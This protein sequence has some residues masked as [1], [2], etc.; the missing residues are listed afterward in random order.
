MNNRKKSILLWILSVIIMLA[1]ASWQRMSG[2]TY[3]KSGEVIID[4]EVV[5][6]KLLRSFDSG[7]D[8]L[9]SILIS[10]DNISGNVLYKR[11]NTNDE[12]TKIAMKKCGDTLLAFLP[13]QPPA[14]K[15]TYEVFLESENESIS[16]MEPIV[17]RFKGAVPAYILLPHIFFMFFA[18]LFSF[19]AGFEVIAKGDKVYSFTWIT[20]I[21][22]L[23][24]GLILGPIVQKY[25]FDAYWTGWPNGNDLTDNKT[26]L[27]FVLWIIALFVQI[28]NRKKTAWVLVACL[29]LFIIYLVP[30]SMF[31]SE[32]DY[33]SGKVI[34]G[35]EK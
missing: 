14:G 10:G 7:K 27:A 11:F 24:G 8:A 5:E 29:V 9:V 1:A 19:R 18:M 35:A 32:L 28:K 4:N 17:I 15:L 20:I 30:H 26:L 25:A 2:P 31:G 13:T 23:L 16:L 34:T 3:P 12:W 21:L 6:F 33:D 22:L